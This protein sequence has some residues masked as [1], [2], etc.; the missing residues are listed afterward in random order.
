[1]GRGRAEVRHACGRP[2][3]RRAIWRDQECRTFGGNHP[4][5]GV[6]E[7]A[8]FNQ[9][10]QQ[11]DIVIEGS[12]KNCRRQITIQIARQKERFKWQLHPTGFAKSLRGL[13]TATE[14]RSSNM[15]PTT[16]TGLWKGA[17]RSLL[18]TLA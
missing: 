6:D 14:P 11:D 18:T 3:R 4:G 2:H 13:K 5:E 12:L 9:G 8:R 1:M 7:T 15:C 17:I 10:S 16:W